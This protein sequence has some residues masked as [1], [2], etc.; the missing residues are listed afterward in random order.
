MK[1]KLYS[2]SKKAWQAMLE[3]I[4]L[5]QKSVF[6]EMY[7]FSNDSSEFIELLKEKAQAGLRVVLIADFFGSSSLRRSTIKGL[8]DSGVEFLFF[9]KWLRNTHRKVLILDERV[10]FLGGVNIS[11]KSKDWVDLQVKIVGPRLA[12]NVLKSFAR[13][14]YLSGGK[15][16]DLL[17]LKRKNIFKTIKAQ[18]LDHW[19]NHKIFT[20]QAYYKRKIILSQTSILIV[21]PY[22]T[23]PKWL[24]FL[25]EDAIE[26]GVE[27]E[28]IIPWKSDHKILDKINRAFVK[29]Y[30]YLP[31]KFY[32]HN[33]MNHAKILVVDGQETLIGSQ[34]LDFLSFNRNLESG[35]FIK[36][37]KLL[38]ELDEIISAW[39]RDSS[40][41]EINHKNLNFIERIFIGLIRIFYSIL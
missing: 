5:A 26:R 35:V 2:K 34:N 1:Y 21:T 27:V 22:F 30:S 23:P 29:R 33:K 40:D 24:M 28:I 32:A 31:I 14:Y 36:D 41:F 8:R 7:I 10:V 6:I 4:R 18:F 16:E 20:L 39:K 37:K 12:K 38:A 3:E 17:A 25:I 9:R 15:D 13:S 19:P 11:R